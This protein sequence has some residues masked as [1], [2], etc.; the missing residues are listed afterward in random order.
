MPRS[1]LQ[2]SAT[3]STLTCHQ[4]LL[5]ASHVL[6]VQWPAQAMT[7]MVNSHNMHS[8]KSGLLEDGSHQ[9]YAVHDAF[10]MFGFGLCV[11][12]GR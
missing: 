8:S 1:R 2:L 3:R 11:C 7:D 9:L 10:V 12:F 5:T 6:R 4:Y